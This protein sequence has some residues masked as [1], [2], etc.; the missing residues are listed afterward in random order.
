MHYLLETYLGFKYEYPE[1]L[2]IALF[3]NWLVNTTGNPGKFS[4]LDLMQEHHNFWLKE[5]AQ[6][7][8][9]EFSDNWYRDVLSMHVH[10]FLRLKEEM[11]NNMDI[12]LKKKT[13]T[14]PH[15]DNEVLATIRACHEHDLHKYHRGCALGHSAVDD[16]AAG[17]LLLG[18][19]GKLE[20]YIE[21]V[22]QHRR[23]LQDV[24]GEEGD[25]ADASTYM[26]QPVV[27]EDG[28]LKLPVN[29]S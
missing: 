23:L 28:Q 4:E 16:F 6:H 22:M 7:K 14:S 24:W 26:C 9:K 2:R 8:G 17:I 12:T 27:Y 18:R 21:K 3:N 5:L 15:L 1:P 20:Q 25:A 19:E 11:E 13:H 29:D 10:H